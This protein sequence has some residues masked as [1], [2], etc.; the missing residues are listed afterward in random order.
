[1][2]VTLKE[3]LEPAQHGGYAVGAFDLV[4]LETGKALLDAAE[5]LSSPI[6]LMIGEEAGSLLPYYLWMPALLWMAQASVVP[7]SISLDH[8]TS[9]NAVKS[10]IDAGVTGV[11]FDGSSLP[12]DENVRLTREVVSLAHASGVSV[13]A[14]V[15]HVGEAKADESASALTDPDEAAE[16]VRATGVDALA[17]AIGS[18]HGH[19]RQTPQL[20]LARLEAIR[21]RVR[22]PLVLHGGSGIPAESLQRSVELGICKVNVY[23]DLVTSAARALR[24]SLD[25]G[26]DI[27]DW[28]RAI[29]AGFTQA[30]ASYLEILGS[31]GRA[32]EW[33]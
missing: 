1:M 10:A 15:G 12:W 4:S 17:V 30:T 2:L 24:Q 19:Y 29:N 21:A 14:E 11:M 7:V 25:R 9:L 16:F 26:E 23:T 28:L 3:I 33:S 13:E 27:V 22:V 20:D 31:R 5:F 8:G 6:I 32:R 18:A